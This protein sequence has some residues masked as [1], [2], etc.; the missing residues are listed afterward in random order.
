MNKNGSIS[1]RWKHGYSQEPLYAVWKTMLARCYN[2]KHNRYA[3][4]GGRGITVTEEWF[5]YP[6]FRKWAT[7]SGYKLGLQIDRINPDGAY[8]PANTRWTTPK[9]QQRN[10]R[11]NRLETYQGRTMTLA[12]W[13]EQKECVV[14][15]KVLWERL[16]D[17]WKF[18]QALT[19]PLRRTGG[20]RMISAFGEEKSISEWCADPRCGGATLATIW[21]RLNSG[22]SPERA[23]ATPTRKTV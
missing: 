13:A 22:W 3:L 10:R 1:Q 6:A 5:E 14:P 20:Y 8:E 18:H 21:K 15:Y 7:G 16:K 23:I 11:N 2:P 12:E 19:T 4:Y 17:G 9:D